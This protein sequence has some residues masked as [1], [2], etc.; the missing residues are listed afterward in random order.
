MKVNVLGTGY[1]QALLDQPIV[2]TIKPTDVMFTGYRPVELGGQ[3]VKRLQ[4]DL[5]KYAG[6]TGVPDYGTYTG[7]IACDL[8]IHGLETAGRHP[9]RQ[10]FI[11]GI[12]KGGPYD[13]AGLL[14]MPLDFS[15]ASFGK[16]N[17]TSCTWFV[18]VKDGKFTVLNHGKP[19]T[20]KLVGD[21]RLLGQYVNNGGGV[22]TTASSTAAP[23]GP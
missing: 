11:D 16:I 18:A 6:L 2:K 21:P 9:T 20:G 22:A 23:A 14:C 3:A 1:S 5:K 4:A 10:G 17:K 12:R 7:Y 15:Y 13:G 19:Y 8:M